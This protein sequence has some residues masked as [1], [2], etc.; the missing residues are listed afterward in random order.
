MKQKID[1]LNKLTFQQGDIQY[2]PQHHCPNC[3]ARP[4]TTKNGVWIVPFQDWYSTALSGWIHNLGYARFWCE[5]LLHTGLSEGVM[6]VARLG[7]SIVPV[8]F[9][10]GTLGHSLGVEPV[11]LNAHRVSQ[12]VAF[13]AGHADPS[14]TAG[15]VT[16]ACTLYA[17]SAGLISPDS[18]KIQ[19][20]QYIAEAIGQV[21]PAAIPVGQLVGIS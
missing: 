15:Q 11:F 19:I 6:R 3:G 13:L 2:I 12:A 9:D 1:E 8:T 7:D 16:L 21:T 4:Y 10:D 20:E 14:R 5:C 17:V 18:A